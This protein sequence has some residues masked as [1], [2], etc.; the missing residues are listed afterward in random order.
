MPIGTVEF[1]DG[2]DAESDLARLWDAATEGAKR[3]IATAISEAG[4]F[5]KGQPEAGKPLLLNGVDPP[6]RYVDW[7]I[8]RVFYQVHESAGKIILVGFRLVL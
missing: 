5:L 8:V 3:R 7:D 2:G 4:E 6:V 1:D